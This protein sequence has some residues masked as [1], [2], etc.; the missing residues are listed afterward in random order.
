MN[1]STLELIL[2]NNKSNINRIKVLEVILGN[3]IFINIK[4]TDVLFI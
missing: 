1:N 3:K 4:K 2:Y